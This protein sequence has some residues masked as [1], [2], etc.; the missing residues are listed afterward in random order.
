MEE[1][2]RKLASVQKIT[3]LRELPE[4][5]NLYMAEV[6]GWR[7]LVRKE[8]FKEGDPC[9]FI[10]VDSVL[11]QK[12]EFAFFEK[13]NYKVKTQKI[14]G[15][16]SQGLCLPM[17]HL[18]E[19]EYALGKDVTDLLGVTRWEEPLTL[20]TE[21]V[22]E[23]PSFLVSKTDQRR[24]QEFP[25][26][27]TRYADKHWVATEKLEGTSCTIGLWKNDFLVCGRT[28]VLAETNCV[29][30]EMARNYNL[31]DKL[32]ALQKQLSLI[33]STESV[34]LQGEI[35]GRG[36]QKNPYD[37]KEPFFFAFNFCADRRHFSW[38]DLGE[39]CK[40]LDVPRVPEVENP[41]DMRGKTVDNLVAYSQGYSVLNPKKFREGIVF[42]TKEKEYDDSFGSLSFK[43]IN[44]AFLVKAGK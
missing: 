19:G 7:C 21:A 22:G 33:T 35:I 42:R 23:F 25:E 43:V 31:K 39:V 14:R 27:L 30:W 44:P 29:Y 12:P 5:E 41:F 20:G 1:V 34:F 10:E 32:K 2:K 36:V 8:E 38:E 15:V 11:P 17:S 6:L 24:I 3:K 4:F 37:L 28:K 40:N 18:P 9:I 16:F 26:I 13:Y